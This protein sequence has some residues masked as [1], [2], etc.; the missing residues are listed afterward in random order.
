MKPFLIKL[1]LF[2]SLLLTYMGFLYSYNLSVSKSDPKIDLGDCE[3]LIVGDSYLMRALDPEFFEHGRNICQG[4][5]PYALTYWKLQTLLPKNPHVSTV[6]LGL[7]HHNISAYNDEKFIDPQWAEEMFKRSYTIGNPL[8]VETIAVDWRTYVDTVVRQMCLQPKEDHVHYMGK[9]SNSRQSDTSDL[10]RAIEG[11]FFYR[12]KNA[13]ISAVMRRYLFKIIELCRA[14]KVKIV[15]VVSPVRRRY[16]NAIPENFLKEFKG[17]RGEL[18]QMGVPIL[19]AGGL[20]LNSKEFLN[21]DHLNIFGAKKFS[22]IIA[23][24]LG[25][26]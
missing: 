12:G 13:G 9:Y 5:E 22:P 17:L 11:H 23:R 4:A 7:A 18:S 14:R 21:I 15:L 19:A 2:A 25:K 6:L 10:K 3:T 20:R 8:T 1:V 24:K 16:L 26:L